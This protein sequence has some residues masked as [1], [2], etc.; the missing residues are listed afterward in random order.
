MMA[1]LAG[2][3]W[4]LTVVLICIALIAMLGIFSGAC[5]PYICLWRNVYLVLL[6]LV[7]VVA[8]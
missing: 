8:F 2:M 6:F 5:W 3:R 4:Y 1:I 7:V